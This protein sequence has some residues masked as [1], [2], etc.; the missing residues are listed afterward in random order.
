MRIRGGSMALPL[1][2][3]S[4]SRPRST[5]G[6]M[7]GASGIDSAGTD[8]PEVTADETRLARR[9]AEG[10]GAAFA[11]L[12]DRYEQRV[13]QFCQRITGSAEDAADAT[14]EAFVAVL[15]RLPKLTDR[16]LNFAAYLFTT[17][18]HSAYR[19]IDKRKKADPTDDL[20]ERGAGTGGGFDDDPGDPD[21][22]PERRQ[23]ARGQQEEIRSAHARLPERQ[24]EVL[25]LREVEELSYDEIAEIMDM[26]R[27]SVAQLISRARINLRGELRGEAL[28]SIAVSS[29]ECE[30]ALPLIAMRDDNQLADP[31]DAAWLE[32]HL[33]TCDTCRASV[34]AMHEAGVSYRAL[35]PIVPFLWLRNE[36]IAK[37][38]ERMGFDGSNV[39][40]RSGGDGASGG[41]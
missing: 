27:N 37:A 38:A 26:N 36:T 32:Q 29:P 34:E 35:A 18:R 21:E 23:L 2:P 15:E 8:D 30:K 4:L 12:Y 31:L 39:P 25:V 13:F 24:R 7:S 16:D 14:Q 1:S 3:W 41:S 17:A 40:G 5:F 19:V 9:A 6:S 22:D 11:L 10:D 20:P 33:G 28:A